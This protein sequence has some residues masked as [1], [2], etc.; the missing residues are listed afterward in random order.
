MSSCSGHLPLRKWRTER[1]LWQAEFAPALRQ[2][3]DLLLV[4][5]RQWH[6]EPAIEQS[7]I[8][9]AHPF[10]LGKIRY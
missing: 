10:A 7:D 4:R 8:A 3:S 1:R 5:Q 9:L 6:T 2:M